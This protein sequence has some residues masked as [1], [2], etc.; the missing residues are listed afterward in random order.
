MIAPDDAGVIIVVPRASE[1]GLLPS[2]VDA[3]T[4]L[5]I[6]VVNPDLVDMGVTGL[7]L[8]ARKLRI[9]LIDS[10]ETTYYLK[11]FT[12]GVLLRAYP[13]NWGVWVDADNDVGFRL[14]KEVE[15]RPSSEQ[16]D[17]VLSAEGADSVGIFGKIARFLN[18]YMKG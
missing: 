5:P 15:R 6:V 4:E 13:G 9:N 2:T 16:I 3:A 1:V 17:E 8:N 7:S 18:Q 10:F 11:T 14:V 12:W